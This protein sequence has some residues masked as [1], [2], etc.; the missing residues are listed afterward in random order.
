MGCREVV[1]NLKADM[2]NAAGDP[3][4]TFCLKEEE[5]ASQGKIDLASAD[6]RNCGSSRTVDDHIHSHALK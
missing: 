1:K 6:G 5:H 2:S 4:T 3:T